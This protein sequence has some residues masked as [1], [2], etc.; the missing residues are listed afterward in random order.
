MADHPVALPQPHPND[1]E[2]VVWGLSTATALWARGEHKDAI[3][4]LRRAAEAASS[5][6]QAFRASELGMY[7]QELED[8]L[9][10]QVTTPPRQDTSAPPTAA[11]TPSPPAPWDAMAARGPM[12][13][14]DIEV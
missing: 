4:W 1:D 11:P 8:S 9:D 6:G 7:A 13:S 3:V 14:I 5:A 12:R 10:A 2:D